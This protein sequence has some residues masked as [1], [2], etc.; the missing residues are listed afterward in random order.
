[1]PSSQ[2]PTPRPTLRPK[3]EEANTSPVVRRPVRHSPWSAVSANMA[4]STGLFGARMK[5]ARICST[6]IQPMFVGPG[7]QSR[8]Y[9]KPPRATASTKT[10]FL[11]SHFTSVGVTVTPRIPKMPLLDQEPAEQRLPGAGDL[12]QPRQQRRV[13]AEGAR[14]PGHERGRVDEVLEV[15]G[16][17]PAA[18]DE[19]GEHQHQGADQH[20]PRLAGEQVLDVALQVG[21]LAGRRRHALARRG[22]ADQEHH[23]RQ[24]AVEHH[25]QL[26]A[27]L[28]VALA[29]VADEAEGEVLHEDGR[30][31]GADEAQRGER[32]ALD[33]VGRDARPSAR[34]TGCSPPCR[35]TSAG[36]R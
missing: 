29:E 14:E 13:R 10:R 23:D 3:S 1:M 17:H 6:N 33:R 15:V 5:L 9:T 26:P 24:D 20:A 16:R 19:G 4:K 34:C 8:Q 22:E 25:R 28:V 7:S 2:P 21:A 11:P 30:G 12:H 32:R 36:R 35:G 27:A 31:E 18:H